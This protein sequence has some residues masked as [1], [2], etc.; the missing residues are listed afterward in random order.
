MPY[1]VHVSNLDLVTTAEAVRIT[2]YSRYKLYR[3][4]KRGDL[5]YALKPEGTTSG[6]LF[7]RADIEALRNPVAA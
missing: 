6:Y 7:E 1:F 2:G 5:R 3:L 4:I